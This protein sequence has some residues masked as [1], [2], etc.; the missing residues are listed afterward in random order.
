MPVFGAAALAAAAGQPY[1]VVSTVCRKVQPILYNVR[2][3]FGAVS[4]LNT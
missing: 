1:C 3:A 2:A 4:D